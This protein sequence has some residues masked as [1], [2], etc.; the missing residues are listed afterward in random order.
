MASATIVSLAVV[1]TVLVLRSS[2]AA[3]G[4][5]H[6]SGAIQAEADA[7]G[8]AILARCRERRAPR[9]SITSPASSQSSLRSSLAANGERHTSPSPPFA[10]ARSRLRSSL[11]ANG[12]RHTPDT[13][14]DELWITELRSSLAANGE[15]HRPRPGRLR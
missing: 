14:T 9:P 11:A 15:R 4:E 3:N 6:A 12:E 5:R 10:S 8:V 7:L 13:T 1:A 2:L